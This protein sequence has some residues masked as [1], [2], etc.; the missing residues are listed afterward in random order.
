[1]RASRGGMCGDIRVAHKLDKKAGVWGDCG[2]REIERDG[3]RTCTA[4]LASVGG[5]Q[6][7]SSMT[8]WRNG[9]N[10]PAPGTTASYAHTPLLLQNLLRIYR[11]GK[12]AM[13]FTT[14]NF[15]CGEELLRFLQLR[16]TFLVQTPGQG[17]QELQQTKLQPYSLARVELGF[18][19]T[20]IV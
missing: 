20:C 4:F 16:R 5:R 14:E 17:L 6:R 2:G 7:N 1:M 15:Y 18:E 3:Q 12:V 19:S 13:I 10:L 8:G 9:G 11:A